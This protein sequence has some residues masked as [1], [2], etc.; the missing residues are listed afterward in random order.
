MQQKRIPL[1]NEQF[2]L[3]VF[4]HVVRKSIWLILIVILCF[5]LGS[6]VYLRYTPPVFQAASILQVSSSN[7]TNK[8]LQLEGVYEDDE[9][10]QVIELIRSKEFLK[11]TFSKLPIEISY[12]NKGTFLSSELYRSSPYE[13]TSNVHSNFMYEVPFYISFEDEDSFVLTYSLGDVEYKYNLRVGEWNFIEGIDL[14]IDVSN[15]NQIQQAQDDIKHDSYLFVVN[16]PS[17]LLAKHIENLE[18]RLL[19]HSAKTIEISYLDN[20]AVKTSEIVNTVAEEFLKYEIE[21]KK[22]SADNVLDFIE[23]QLKIVYGQLSNVETK[24]H[25]FKTEKGVTAFGNNISYF[26]LKEKKIEEIQ[27]EIMNIEMEL[28]VLS[29]IQNQ[30]KNKGQLDVY[31]LI[32]IMSGVSK[33]GNVINIL[34]N[35][36]NLI[37]E[38][39]KLLIDYTFENQ[40]VNIVNNQIENQKNVL[41]DFVN[42]SIERY[43]INKDDYQKK[44]KE[45][46][47]DLYNKSSID[48]L[49]LARLNRLYTINQGFYNQL[50][51]KK[52]EYLIF[53]AGYVSDNV[54]LEKSTVP[55]FAVSPI[56]QQVVLIAIVV[57]LL[58]SIVIILLKYLLYNEIMTVNDIKTYTTAPVIGSIPLY[59]KQLEYSQ[60]LVDKKPNSIL[61]EGFRTVRSNLEFI[62]PQGENRLISVSST[63]SGE[64]K[65]FVAINLAGILA[66]SGKTVLLIDLDL[67]KPKIHLGFDVDNEKGISTILIGKNNVEDCIKH[68]TL[69]NLDFITAGPVPP[70]PSELTTSKEMTDLLAIVRKQY[71]YVIIDNPPLGLVTDAIVNFAKADCPIYVAK[72]GFSKRNYIYN[73][74][75]LLEEKKLDKLTIILNGVDVQSGLYGQGY[76]YG[77]GYLDED[78][79]EGFMAKIFKKKKSNN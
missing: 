22:E 28:A 13:V 43:K 2:D 46:E 7:K 57:S 66:V 16:N 10:A 32:A 8:I 4:L 19:N 15:F 52:A 11:R 61:S 62:I 77:Y 36:Q 71:D 1:I 20:N 3:Y 70:N 37:S 69:K 6:F 59:K 41:L 73:I 67:R 79:N 65:T 29:S 47:R 75:H 38:R 35:I 24:I 34:N 17:T 40:K 12:Y 50:L 44:I 54:I 53:Q 51:E 14:M 27:K 55:R 63:V 25:D 60:L 26:S 21:K 64:G 31:R 68:S 39:E 72:A 76:G 56:K 45:F 48:E 18:I 33:D 74:N 78:E 23:H 30:L 42:A 49:E 9:I 5:V 58:L